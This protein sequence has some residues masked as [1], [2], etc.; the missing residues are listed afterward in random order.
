MSRIRI[1]GTEEATGT[2]TIIINPEDETSK[3]KRGF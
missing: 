3:Y 2:N 1:I